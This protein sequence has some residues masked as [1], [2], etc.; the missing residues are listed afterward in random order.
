MLKADGYEFLGEAYG[1]RTETQ[2][3]HL[4]YLVSLELR[5]CLGDW[6]NQST[7]HYSQDV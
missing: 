5:T 4:K 2:I 7:R 1:G 3:F 6:D